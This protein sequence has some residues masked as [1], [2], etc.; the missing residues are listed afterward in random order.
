[1][2]RDRNEGSARRMRDCA[3]FAVASTSIAALPHAALPWQWMA[4]MIAPAALLGLA[5][6]FPAS[7]FYRAIL[8]TMLQLLACIA[9]YQGVGPIT[10][11]AALAGT[12]LPPLVFVVVRRQDLDAT[13]GLFLG[14]C[15]LVVAAI[16]TPLPGWL[17]ACFLAAA[18]CQLRFDALL[19]A[20]HNARNN[21]AEHHVG[22][23][24]VGHDWGLLSIIVLALL[25]C[26]STERLLAL[27][28]SLASDEVDES[29]DGVT[30]ANRI[31]LSDTF[32]FGASGSEILDLD[33][34]LLVEVRDLDNLPL[35]QPLY[36]RTGHFERPALD[37][38]TVGR[39]RPRRM[40]LT[41]RP[42][43]IRPPQRQRPIARLECV[44]SPAARNRLFVPPGAT[45]MSGLSD[46]MVDEWR[47]WFRQ[48]SPRS[49]EIYRV[50]YQEPGSAVRDARIERSWVVAGLTDLPAE[51]DHPVIREIWRRCA[52]TGS[53]MQKAGRIAAELQRLCRYVRREPDGPYDHSLL[54]FLAGDR[55]G[56][57][58]HF[59]SAAA[60]LLRMSGVPC[61][62]G[63]GLYGGDPGRA[64]DSRRFGS[65]HAHAWVEIPC[66]D[67]GWIVFDPTPAAGRGRAG[68]D[69]DL[70]TD[71]GTQPETGAD[72]EKTE[73]QSWMA[74][75]RQVAATP[76]PWL[77]LLSMLMTRPLIARRRQ[78]GAVI[79]AT[80]TRPET[81]WL[82]RILS[83]L[84]RTGT[85]VTSHTT[86][87]QLR[88]HL[89]GAGTLHPAL[90]AAL[91]TY[92]EVRFGRRDWDREAERQM[93][94]GLDATAASSD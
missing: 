51:I 78:H 2:N 34:E 69:P 32:E 1:M 30:S 13:L 29:S 86:V 38:W 46:V 44:R 83:K 14:L 60:I 12:I 18:V 16:L 40:D 63:V 88:R 80:L 36:L 42:L 48:S 58:M 87:E 9:A 74:W 76:W 17:V 56:F 39:L 19:Q 57:C 92:Q 10:R 50:D 94:A 68:Q 64:P 6:S 71:L 82:R 84:A 65:Q 62:I 47:G 35:S 91:T 3:L 31:G 77:M 25:T 22:R 23:P 11:P 81:R 66:E 67:L 72:G 8:A 90:A 15:T 93:R 43:R 7:P 85:P 4:A 52:A 49:N 61:R 53:P 75:L 55:S 21:L 79:R 33:G 28:P 41:S 59:A 54:N 5:R 27:L 70:S 89:Q 20:Q 26:A 73:L 24:D 37:S 45:S